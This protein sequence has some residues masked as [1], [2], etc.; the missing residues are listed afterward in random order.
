VLREKSPY[1]GYEYL[2]GLRS[3]VIESL[4]G[5]GRHSRVISLKDLKMLYRITNYFNPQQIL[6]VGTCYGMTV[7]GMLN[8]SSESRL[9]LYE[10]SLGNY[11]VAGEVLA[12]YLDSI[13]MYN[14][15][16]VALD[17]YKKAMENG[18]EPFVVINSISAEEDH[19]A[20]MQ[21]LE[22]V[23]EGEGVIV[24]R[25]LNGS[26]MMKKMWVGLKEKMT[27]GQSFTN[28][29]IG[30]MVVSEKLNLEHFFLWF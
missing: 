24:M 29:K 19:E 23:L 13:E 1:Y 22:T 4:R 3:A 17:D 27:R 20:L 2:D 21:Y 11:P 18:G 8:V 15:L 6:Q 7:A 16:Q 28:E 30:V 5:S 14:S 25:N 12:P 26:E 9:W 10:P